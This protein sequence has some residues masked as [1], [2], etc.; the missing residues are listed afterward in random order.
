[1]ATGARVRA[2]RAQG[3]SDDEIA[4]VLSEQYP[5]FSSQEIRDLMREMDREGQT[6]TVGPLAGGYGKPPVELSK[7]GPFSTGYAAPPELPLEPAPRVSQ[8]RPEN[9]PRALVDAMD[10]NAPNLRGFNSKN[11]FSQPTPGS[12]SEAFDERTRELFVDPIKR[13]F[14]HTAQ[15]S[16]VFTGDTAVESLE[17]AAH[18]IATREA[19][20]RNAPKADY[21][22]AAEEQVK[23]IVEDVMTPEQIARQ[24]ERRQYQD[25]LENGVIP[26]PYL[27]MPQIPNERE[28]LARQVQADFGIDVPAGEYNLPGDPAGMPPV[29]ALTDGQKARAIAKMTGVYFKDPRRAINVSLE[30][31][32]ASATGLGLGFG[33]GAAGGSVAGVPGAVVGMA[34]GAGTGSFLAE[35]GSDVLDQMRQDGID[36]TN[37]QVV[38]RLLADPAYMERVKEHARNRGAAVATFDALSGALGG[39]VAG[40]VART[41]E[42]AGQVSSKVGQRVAKIG[43]EATEV[44]TQGGLGGLGE[45]AGAKASGEQVDPA[46]VAQEI[47]GEGGS[48]LAEILS[49]RYADQRAAAAYAASPQGQADAARERAL[50]SAL[51]LTA[52]IRA[53]SP[54]AGTMPPPALTGSRASDAAGGTG[55][56]PIPPAAQGTAQ[57]LQKELQPGA[58]FQAPDGE[59]TVVAASP[60]ADPNQHMLGLRGPDGSLRPWTVGEFA[61][62]IERETT[63]GAIRE[64]RDAERAQRE[65]EAEQAG[66]AARS[67]QLADLSSALRQPA[68]VPPEI[69]EENA[70]LKAS[71]QMHPPPNSA[72]AKQEGS[73]F[74]A[75]MANI[76][77]SQATPPSRLAAMSAKLRPAPP[78]APPSKPVGER[79][80]SATADMQKRDTE[81]ATKKVQSFGELL[82][83][84]GKPES[85]R[86]PPPAPPAPPAAPPPPNAAPPASPAPTEPASTPAPAEEAV[87]TTQEPPAGGATTPPAG[88]MRRGEVGGKLASGER[89]LTSSG[90]VT[91]PFPNVDLTT[92]RKAQNTVKAVERWLMQN[93]LDEAGARA[94]EFNARNFAANLDRPQQADKDSAEEY[95]FGEQPEVPAKATKGKKAK[96]AKS[97]ADAP[98]N[99]PPPPPPRTKGAKRSNHAEAEADDLQKRIKKKWLAYQTLTAPL[100]AQGKTYRIATWDRLI[101]EGLESVKAATKFSDYLFHADEL[102]QDLDEAVKEARQLNAREEERAAGQMMQLDLPSPPKEPGKATKDTASQVQKDTEDVKR[103]WDEYQ[104]L[105]PQFEMD[106]PQQAE[107]NED[108]IFDAV[109]GID[110]TETLAEH[111]DALAALRK[112]LE[113]AVKTAEPKAPRPLDRERVF[114][115]GAGFADVP[116]KNSDPGDVTEMPTT[117]EKFEEAVDAHAELFGEAQDEKVVHLFVS[118]AYTGPFLSREE[119]ARRIESWQQHAKAQAGKEDNEFRTIISVFD[120]TGHWSQPWQDAGYD[121]VRLDLQT[122]DDIRDFMDAPVEWLEEKVPNIL[123]RVD[124]M[125]IAVPCTDF[126]NS[127]S[128]H[129][130]HKDP[131]GRTELSKDLVFASLNL[132]ELVDPRFWALENPTGRI[133]ELTGLPPARLIFN[134]NAY[135]DPY[136]KQTQLWGNFNANLPTAVVGGRKVDGGD[137]SIMHEKYGGGSTRTKN[138]RSVTPEGFAAAFFMAN[139]YA[140]NVQKK[141]PETPPA[142]AAKKAP[143][144]PPAAPPAPV[145]EKPA[146]APAPTPAPPKEPEEKQGI[147]TGAH[148]ILTDRREQVITPEG[149][150]VDTSFEVVEAADLISSDDSRFPKKLQPRKRERKTSEDQVR[151]IIAN[152]DPLQL[153]PSRLASHGAPIIGM[154]D[155]YVESGNGRVMAIR[156]IYGNNPELAKKYRKYVGVISGVDVSK[157]K[158]PVLVRRRQTEMTDEQRVK[159][160]REANKDAQMQ[161]SASEK[162]AIDQ[163]KLT[164]AVM[165]ELPENMDEPLKLVEGKGLEFVERFVA[166]FTPAERGELIDS[167]GKVSSIALNRA[168]SALL[169][170]AYGGTPAGDA[171]IRRAAESTDTDAQTLVNILTRFAPAFAQLK[172]EIAAGRVQDQADIGPQIAEAVEVVRAAGGPG[173]VTRWLNTEGLLDQKDPTVKQ[174]IQTFYSFDG[175]GDAKRIR[176]A[177]AIGATL[178]EYLKEAR[179]HTPAGAGGGLFGDEETAVLNPAATLAKLNVGRKEQEQRSEQQE[180]TQR[181]GQGG[182]FTAGGKPS[183]SASV[184][185]SDARGGQ[186][187]QPAGPREDGNTGDAEASAETDE[188]VTEL[189]D[190]IGTRAADDGVEMAQDEAVAEEADTDEDA[191]DSDIEEGRF[192]REGERVPLPSTTRENLMRAI[193]LDPTEFR[194][195]GG[196]QQWETAVKALKQRFG[197]ANIIKHASQNWRN[198]VDHLLDGFES[199]DNLAEALKAGSRIVSLNGRITLHMREKPGKTKGYFRYKAKDNE[200]DNTIAL[201]NQEDVYSHELAHGIDYDLMERAGGSLPGGLTRM[202]RERENTGT[203]PN[204]LLEAMADVYN[205]IYYDG[206]AIAALIRK[207]QHQ[208]QNA[209]TPSDKAR[210]QKRLTALQNGTWRGGGAFSDF[211]KRAKSGPS[212]RYLTKPTEFFARVFEAYI[213]HKIQAQKDMNLVKFL[214]ATDAIYRDD[215]D[216]WIKRVYPH[217]SER[218]RIFATLDNLVGQIMRMDI[219]NVGTQS[220]G[221]QQSHVNLGMID[222]VAQA[223]ANGTPITPDLIRAHNLTQKAAMTYLEDEVARN[224]SMWKNFK[225]LYDDWREGRPGTQQRLNAAMSKLAATPDTVMQFLE[226]RFPNIPVLRTIRNQLSD[227]HIAGRNKPIG[228][229]REWQRTEHSITNDLEDRMNAVGVVRNMPKDRAEHFWDVAHGLAKPKNAAEKLQVDQFVYELARLW[230]LRDKTGENIGYVDE[231]YVNRVFLKDVADNPQF[232]ADLLRLRVKEKN[233]LIVSLQAQ[234]LAATTPEEVARL[235]AA[236]KRAQAIDPMA[237]TR[238]QVAKMKGLAWGEPVYLGAVSEDS[239]KERVFSA[240]ADEILKEWYVKDPATLLQ[241]YGSAAARGIAMRRRFG[242][243]P[244]KVFQDWLD[245]TALELPEAYGELLKNAMEVAMGFRRDSH[246]SLTRMVNGAANV[247]TANMLGR[248]VFPNISEPLNVFGKGLSVPVTFAALMQST[249]P[250]L[251]GSTKRKRFATA[252]RFGRLSGTLVDAASSTTA[253]AQHIGEDTLGNGILARFSVRAYWFNFMSSLTAK[254][255]KV[256]NRVAFELF[257]HV[258]EQIRKGGK[259]VDLYRQWFREHGITDP[260]AFAKFL[261][262]IDNIDDV[263]L[264]DTLFPG[265]GL[266]LSNAITQF[267]HTTIQHPTPSTKHI[268]A[269]R[270]IIGLLFRL[271]SWLTTNFANITRYMKN[272]LATALSGRYG[273]EEIH[274]LDRLSGERAGKKLTAGERVFGRTGGVKITAAQRAQAMV[275]PAVTIALTMYA[276]QAF[277]VVA[278]MMLTNRDEWEDRG[279]DFWQRFSNR[280]TQ[281]Q[282]MQYW[283]IMGWGMNTAVDAV[284]GTRYNRGVFGSLAGPAYGPWEQDAERLMIGAVS[285]ADQ[286]RGEKDVSV[287]VKNNAAQAAYHI[288][289]NIFSVGLLNVLKTRGITSRTAGFLWSVIGTSPQARHWFADYLAGEKDAELRQDAKAGDIDA[290]DELNQRNTDKQENADPFG[291]MDPLQ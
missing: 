139:N 219:Y 36:L 154:D 220:P 255:Q 176:S 209:K 81:G 7:S 286:M 78:P 270:N 39:R 281:L 101:G 204:T 240:A 104:R 14:Q 168:K 235:K 127:G 252:D 226:M 157:M 277:F 97:A 247:T 276:A 59:Y 222:P 108:K 233:D 133:A 71:A 137:G 210:L 280:K 279:E 285:L 161:M 28:E 158:E 45:V 232:H 181:G 123:G 100:R 11:P 58:T 75:L 182:L 47:V 208:L 256:M 40:P 95:L 49:G 131:D 118:P 33:L 242:D 35:Y 287:A 80:T 23:Q 160:T 6:S 20:I 227:A 211:Y 120:L 63:M 55:S 203:L 146:A 60:H 229:Y 46:A 262:K 174:L 2:A 224:E 194:I 163:E 125:L 67:K 92:D 289:S 105:V 264:T 48:G 234:R 245:Q 201:F 191:E 83:E 170:K 188:E 25:D 184:G 177:A 69:A 107:T 213:S 10:P 115:P 180:A 250:F 113:K 230:K 290:M 88:E 217:G 199:L 114:K 246:G 17:S 29:I 283:G 169:Q 51:D 84:F 263:D 147:Y 267:V 41:L 124:G 65:A 205:A 218:Q 122:G 141:K 99:L 140:D 44:L 53:S 166:Q 117:P 56:A 207:V 96:P 3:F 90:R 165:S 238:S 202:I 106:R 143:T 26:H 64:R 254:Q 251:A 18:D 212:A 16:N 236:I 214:G 86:K 175:R 185:Q 31:L 12:Y 265:T 237:A 13:G 19:L 193:G 52:R 243:D 195:M 192:E 269:N 274:L 206:A 98:L 21:M 129:W 189:D 197:F 93:A 42:N 79:L 164:P 151:H 216:A 149:T 183:A 87:S 186:A 241:M 82:T 38:A 138:A 239:A 178:A 43:G 257:F 8:P 103:L 4:D 150:Q 76:A 112:V 225:Q 248:A 130:K 260:D 15:A 278:R 148:P 228:F 268:Q 119:G 190:D 244:Q 77:A 37:E 173:A 34:A 152:F 24:Y 159:W 171:A 271:T 261:E 275:A 172:D 215:T 200:P 187:A 223:K 110:G 61:A 22:V 135:G 32:T 5:E 91:T 116:P 266:T 121:V 282:I 89:V 253:M 198:A 9:A 94:D 109:E 111:A 273:G 50:S 68:R 57:A 128:G 284:E 30:S 66:V 179:Q 167:D 62:H 102:H 259:G 153:G 142:P 155:N 1:M 72:A 231:S 74:D 162:A 291:F 136:T 272:R 27:P 132:V 70:L 73:A 134:P 85:E 221:M 126:T 249:L 196:K 144:P 258:A 156:R 54:A 288:G 145:A